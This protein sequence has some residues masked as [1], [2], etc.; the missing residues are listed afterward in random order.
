MGILEAMNGVI[1]LGS[2]TILSPHFI[3]TI[4]IENLLLVQ[5]SE[6]NACVHSSG[7]LD[8]PIT[9][10]YCDYSSYSLKD[11]PIHF[12][13]VISTEKFDNTH[14]FMLSD[15]ESLVLWEYGDNSTIFYCDGNFIKSL[16]YKDKCDGLVNSH[17]LGLT[18]CNEF[19][20]N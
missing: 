13:M 14:L 16:I 19:D 15:D 20:T 18:E 17:T 4:S 3:P 10:A 8:S 9:M 7:I 1:I 12:I 11:I 6:V 2:E 5:L